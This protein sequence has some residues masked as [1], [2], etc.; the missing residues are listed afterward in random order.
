MYVRTYART[1]TCTYVCTCVCTYA[2]M[3]ACKC[4]GFHA[5]PVCTVFPAGVCLQ[6][7][8]P[9]PVEG[10]SPY[11]GWSQLAAELIASSVMVEPNMYVGRVG[12]LINLGST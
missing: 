11:C 12:L 4:I 5:C 9:E 6:G 2:G 10:I 7:S 1:C 8:K 3:N